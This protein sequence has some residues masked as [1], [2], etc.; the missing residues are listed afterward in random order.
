MEFMWKPVQFV[1]SD[2]LDRIGQPTS[3]FYS[4]FLA[5]RNGEITQAELIKR[6]PHVALIGDSVCTGVYISSIWSTFW[7][8]RT[9]SGNS[10]FLDTRPSP[11]GIRSVS[12]RLEEFTPFVAIECAGIGA[13]VD[14][15]GQRQNFF[16]RILRTRNFSQQIRGLMMM[17]RFPDLILISIGHN[18]VDWAWQCAPAEIEQPENR[19]RQLS[20]RFREHFAR[21]MRRLIDHARAQRHAVAIVVYGLV[22]FE[23]YFRGREIAERLRAKDASRYPHLETT[24]KYFTSFRPAYRSNLIRLARLMNEELRALVSG[25]NGELADNPNL[26]LRYSDGLA[27]ADLS[28]VE[29]LHPIDGWHASVEGHNVLAAAAFRDLEPSLEFLGIK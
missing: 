10:W 22:N 2:F 9:C 21:Q 23:S 11:A 13:L 1:S 12:K 16:R 18:N 8:A 3:R 6:L 24:Y 20:R 14:Y 19:L 26:Q 15:E 28:R 29:L 17:Q 4:D 5:Y 27:T 25:M 7:R